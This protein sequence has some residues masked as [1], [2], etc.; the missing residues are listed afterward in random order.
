MIFLCHKQTCSGQ[1]AAFQPNHNMLRLRI[2]SFGISRYLH[3]VPSGQINRQIPFGEHT[4]GGFSSFRSFL[5]TQ[6]L[7]LLAEMTR[8]QFKLLLFG[9]KNLRHQL[10]TYVLS[11]R[12]W[13]AIN[14]PS[15]C[16]M[17]FT[18]VQYFKRN[19]HSFALCQQNANLV[20]SRKIWLVFP[21]L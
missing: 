15:I 2:K 19:M 5:W 18:I 6:S 21:V 9:Q 17:A 11:F 16:L 1:I 12:F 4:R 8:T 7:N 14:D 10:E 20:L 3:Y 13:F